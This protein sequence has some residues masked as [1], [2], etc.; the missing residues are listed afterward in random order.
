MDNYDAPEIDVENLSGG[1]AS[2]QSAAVGP[3]MVAAAVYSVVV[4]F[5]GA[6]VY[7]TA[8]WNNDWSY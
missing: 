4:A 3:V 7:L 6:F 5:G 2:P 1:G 8:T